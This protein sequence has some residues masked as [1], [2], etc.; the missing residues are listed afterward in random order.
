[1]PTAIEFDC[2]PGINIAME[3]IASPANRKANHLEPMP[4]S[5]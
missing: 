4:F 2:T 1:M 3:M 5:I